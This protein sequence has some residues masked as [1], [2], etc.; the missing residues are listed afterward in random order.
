MIPGLFVAL[1]LLAFV[2][3][4]LPPRCSHTDPHGRPTLMWATRGDRLCGWCP[5]CQQWTN[6]WPITAAARSWWRD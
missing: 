3:V 1:V 4:L 6:G 5:D 2:L